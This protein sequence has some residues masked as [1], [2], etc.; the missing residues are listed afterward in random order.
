M[1]GLFAFV[2][3]TAATLLGLHNPLRDRHPVRAMLW[4]GA[5]TSYV[6]MDRSTLT[7]TQGGGRIVCSCDPQ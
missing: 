7:V 4:L 1:V 6:L 2:A 5:L 3:V